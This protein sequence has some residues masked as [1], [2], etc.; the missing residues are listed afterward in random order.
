MRLKRTKAST[1]VSNKLKNIHSIHLIP[2][3]D[4]FIKIPFTACFQGS[5]GSGK[6]V[7]CVQWVKAL[8]DRGFINR[9]YLISP[10]AETNRVFTNLRTL[11]RSDICSDARKFQQGLSDVVA[12]VKKDHQK[13]Q[14]LV[15]YESLYDKYLQQ[16]DL[17]LQEQAVLEKY[18]YCKMEVPPKPSELLIADDVQGKA[19]GCFHQ[20]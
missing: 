19:S 2:T 15:K 6:T 5:R 18:Q 11:D 8:E 3:P 17:T 9:T 14:E 10:T 7:A 12:S 4:D 16:Q 20:P 13:Y 1:S